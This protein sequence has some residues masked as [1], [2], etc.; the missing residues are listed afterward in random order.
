[1]YVVSVKSTVKISSIY[2]AL[3]KTKFIELKWKNN[4]TN[5]FSMTY[6]LAFEKPCCSS[7]ILREPKLF[8]KISQCIRYVSLINA[9]KLA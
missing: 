5:L 7:D 6:L 9:S 3:E 8:E 2:V 1:M 4:K